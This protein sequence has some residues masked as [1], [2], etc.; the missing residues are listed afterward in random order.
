MN[1]QLLIFVLAATFVTAN[2]QYSDVMEKYGK[3]CM[4]NEE[5]I[6]GMNYDFTRIKI[7]TN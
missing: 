2:E 4:K 5:T 1:F 3:E 7:N 6:K